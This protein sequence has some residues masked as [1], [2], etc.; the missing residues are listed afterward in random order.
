MTQNK[1][2]EEDIIEVPFTEVEEPK[3]NTLNLEDIAYMVVVGRAKDGETI[4]RTSG[5][6][7]LIM[8]RGLLEYAI[9]EV[10]AEIA[11]HRK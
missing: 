5:I 6:T 8:I 2:V 10:K 9:D 3:A 11:K 4:F 1:K 7:D